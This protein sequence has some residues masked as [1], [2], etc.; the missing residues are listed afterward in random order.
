M[1]K[2]LHWLPVEHDSVF[3]TATIVDKF[4]HTGLPKYLAPYLSSYH[5]SYST[6]HRVVIISLSFQSSTVL[7]VNLS[8]S[9][10]IVLLLMHPLFGMFLWMRFVRLPPQPLS[11]SSLNLPVHQGIPTLVL[12]IP[13]RSLWCLTSFCSWILESLIVFGSVSP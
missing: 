9:L 2:E 8:N 6:R 5:S 7:F 11:E 3:K 13:W 1:F 10:V 4:L 12:I